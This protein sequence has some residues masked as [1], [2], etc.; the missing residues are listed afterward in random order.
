[1]VSQSTLRDHMDKKVNLPRISLADVNIRSDSY[2][3]AISI[4]P[5]LQND[6]LK[7]MQRIGEHADI[8]VRY[9]VDTGLLVLEVMSRKPLLDAYR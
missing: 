3:I 9:D 7:T 2:N 8:S 5:K 4:N 6:M 1:M